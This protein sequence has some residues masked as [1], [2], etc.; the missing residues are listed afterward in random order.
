[1]PR[2]DQPLSLEAL[3][4]G[5]ELGRMGRGVPWW[6]G[7]WLRYGNARYGERYE[8]ASRITGYDVKTLTKM[9]YVASRIDPSRRRETL[10]WSH[11]AEVAPLAPA[12]QDRWLERAESERMSARSLRDAIKR[13]HAGTSTGRDQEHVVCPSCGHRH[14]H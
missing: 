5:R 10:S 9:V 6:L 11:H 13:A 14:P 4:H 12:E 2:A 7:D 1:M 3:R 8:Q